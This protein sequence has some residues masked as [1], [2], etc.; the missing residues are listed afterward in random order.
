MIKFEQVSKTYH[1]GKKSV[2]ALKPT[3]LEIPAGKIYGIIGRSGAGKST[4]MRLINRLEEPTS[5]KIFIKGEDITHLKAKNLRLLRQQIGM[6]FQHFNLLTSAT[7]GKNVA[8][9]LKLAGTYSQADI[10]QR[11]TSLLARVGIAD[12]INKYPAQLSGGEKQRV[13]IARALATNPSILLCDE[14]TSALDPQTTRE[15]LNLLAEIN[16]ELGLTLVVITHEMD[17]VRRI[18]DE[19]A[20]MQAGEVVEKGAVSDVFLRPQHPFSRQLVN[21]AE[22]LNGSA[23]LSGVLD[24]DKSLLDTAGKLIRVTFEGQATYQPLLAEMVKQTGIGFSI[25][26]GRIDYLGQQPYGQ[27]TLALQGEEIA[28]ALHFLQAAG[29]QL[30]E[31][32]L[33]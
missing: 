32:H 9:P 1:L 10:Q 5:G 30:E 27:L 23:F 31:L 25:L 20:V 33:D 13:G 11:V 17:V 24:K 6:I 28:P 7:V 3:S 12:L 19:V 2:T 4:L 8:L 16:Q 15:V 18:C 26:A 22:E 21:Q 29:V 14:A